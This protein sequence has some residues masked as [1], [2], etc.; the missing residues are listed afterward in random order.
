MRYTAQMP[1]LHNVQWSWKTTIWGKH[2]IGVRSWRRTRNNKILHTHI[3]IR[4]KA[5]VSAQFLTMHYFSQL[6]SIR[7]P[8]LHRVLNKVVSTINSVQSFSFCSFYFSIHSLFLN[9]LTGKN[10]Y[11]PWRLLGFVK[12]TDCLWLRMPSAW[13]LF[14]RYV[15][16]FQKNLLPASLQHIHMFPYRSQKQFQLTLV[17]IYQ[18]T[19][20]HTREQ[21]NFNI[22][23][24]KNL[25]SHTVCDE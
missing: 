18:T 13:M 22:H 3:V 11:D 25:E 1:T 24:C 20:S 9:I 7:V 14:G 21:D 8:T 19:W 4:I 6:V 12:C 16:T 23:D 5:K 17:P 10:K 2:L 15:P